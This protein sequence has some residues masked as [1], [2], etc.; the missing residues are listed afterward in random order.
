MNPYVCVALFAAGFITWGIAYGR[1]TRNGYYLALDHAKWEA[2]HDRLWNRT[3]RT[4]DEIV[5][6]L[7]DEPW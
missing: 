2:R 5:E 1:G 4:V 7:R 3:P 6:K